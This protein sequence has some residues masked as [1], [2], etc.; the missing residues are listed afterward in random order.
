MERPK[1]FR[2]LFATPILLVLVVLATAETVYCRDPQTGTCINVGMDPGMDQTCRGGTQPIPV[3][4]PGAPPPAVW[5]T[6]GGSYANALPC[7]GGTGDPIGTV[8]LLGG[9]DWPTASQR[10][11]DQLSNIGMTDGYN[12]IWTTRTNFLDNGGCVEGEITRATNKGW[13][14]CDEWPFYCINSRW[15]VRCIVHAQPSAY[16]YW[17]SCTPHWDSGPP[18]D[19]PEHYVPETYNGPEYYPGHS[20]YDA[21]RDMLHYQ[22]VQQLGMTFVGPVTFN[23][24]ALRSQCDSTI[25][26]R[27][28][29]KVN[30]IV[31]QQ[32]GRS[33]CGPT[34]RRCSCCCS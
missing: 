34:V 31:L 1:R 11:F 23:N 28:D 15:H 8:F 17:A 30:V 10:A 32:G 25:F 9:P 19:C 16:G 33:C 13:H 3:V 26:S 5:E 6:L 12:A 14:A 7:Q 18:P 24:R 29:S 4:T 21:A 27:A 22:F 2:R 20:G